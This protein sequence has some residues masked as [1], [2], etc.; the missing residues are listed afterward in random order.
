[1]LYE[2]ITAYAVD[3]AIMQEKERIVIILFVMEMKGMINLNN[4]WNNI[5]YYQ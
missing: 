2:L 3:S 1:M 4:F 5:K